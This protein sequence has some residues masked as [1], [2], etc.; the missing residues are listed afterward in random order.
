MTMPNRTSIVL[1]MK[2]INNEEKLQNDEK[3]RKHERVCCMPTKM[4]F[5]IFYFRTP[6]DFLFYLC[7]T[8]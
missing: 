8:I 3:K 4:P 5:S 2:I 7:R 1:N 6:V